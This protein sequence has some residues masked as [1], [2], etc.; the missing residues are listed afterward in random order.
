MIKKLLYALCCFFFLWVLDA[1]AQDKRK[2]I[3]GRIVSDSIAVEKVHVVNKNTQKGTYTNSYGDF[4]IPVQLDDTLEFSSIQFT[5][6]RRIIS[7]IDLQQLQLLIGLQAKTNEL[8][9]VVV[10]SVSYAKGLG[11]PNADKKPLVAEETRLNAH[12]KSSA[13]VVALATLLNQRGGI[14]NLF[15]LLSGQRKRDRKLRQLKN[16]EQLEKRKLET[17]KLVRKHFG[18]D[19]FIQKLPQNDIVDLEIKDKNITYN[20]NSKDRFQEMIRDF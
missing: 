4:A 5:T 10:K 6:Y 13:P 8:E 2:T 20:L 19:F 1:D 17:V 9:E 18:D 14:D 16:Q 12:N 3:T 7:E 11:L 15:Y